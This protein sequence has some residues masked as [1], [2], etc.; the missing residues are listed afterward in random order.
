MN[1]PLLL[2]LGVATLL[3]G[4]NLNAQSMLE[5][6]DAMEKEMNRLKQE[7]ATLKA[8]KPAPTTTASSKPATKPTKAKA[9]DD[10]DEDE[11]PTEPEAEPSVGE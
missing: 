7:I 2:S 6:F 10:D 1:K 8:A 4:T 11:E 3:V 9:A 5:R